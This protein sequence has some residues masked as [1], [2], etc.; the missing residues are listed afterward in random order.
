LIEEIMTETTS[1][2]IV[3]GLRLTNKIIICVNIN[4]GDKMIDF[5]KIKLKGGWA[6]DREK[7]SPLACELMALMIDNR[8]ASLRLPDDA[9]QG[10]RFKDSTAIL[11]RL[12]SMFTE[13]EFVV[14]PGEKID[15]ALIDAARADHWYTYEKEYD[16][17]DGYEEH[18]QETE[19]D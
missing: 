7:F 13:A 17:Y 12:E 10:P 5:S 6:M 2:V 4:K 1:R 15:A 14:A 3:V 16:T 18:K 9:L 8:R 19:N 11:A